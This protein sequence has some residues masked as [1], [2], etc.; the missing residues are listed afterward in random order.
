[1][2]EAMGSIVIPDITVNN[3]MDMCQTCIWVPVTAGGWRLKV[4]DARCEV[5]RGVERCPVVP[6][7]R[8]TLW[9]GKG[10]RTVNPAR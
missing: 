10:K 4:V 2:A 6:E 1:M 7:R 3:V 9:S 8:A 5:H